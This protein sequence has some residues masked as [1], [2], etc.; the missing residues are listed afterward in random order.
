MRI[1]TGAILEF[2]LLLLLQLV[3]LSQSKPATQ[4][5]LLNKGEYSQFEIIRIYLIDFKL[6]NPLILVDS[7]VVDGN[8]WERIGLKW[9]D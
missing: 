7:K 8:T 9:R 3:Q 6:E 5:N 2:A 4:S 1:H